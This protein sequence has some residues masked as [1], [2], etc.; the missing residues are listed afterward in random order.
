MVLIIE[1]HVFTCGNN[2]GKDQLV[3]PRSLISALVVYCLECF[4]YMHFVQEIKQAYS[5]NNIFIISNI[6]L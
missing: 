2:K 6:S 3:Y 1:K 5:L 4:F